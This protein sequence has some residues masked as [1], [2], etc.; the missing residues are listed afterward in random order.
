MTKVANVKNVDTSTS[1]LIDFACTAR[2]ILPSFCLSHMSPLS[3][4]L[5]IGIKDCATVAGRGD[6][7]L[8]LK[9]DRNMVSYKL[10]NVLHVPSLA[11]FAVS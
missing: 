1:W 2:I 10:T 3:H 5:L 9:F 8:R 11:Y 4:H 6:V 7:N